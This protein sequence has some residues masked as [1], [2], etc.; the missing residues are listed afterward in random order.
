MAW[1]DSVDAYPGMPGI[2]WEWDVSRAMAEAYASGAP[3]RL[4]LYEADWSY[5][6][7]KYFHRHTL[8]GNR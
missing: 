4:V 1:V 3:L 2:P 5:H 8:R 6:R 7:G